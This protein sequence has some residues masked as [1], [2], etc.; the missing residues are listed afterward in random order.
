MSNE[1]LYPKS[2]QVPPMKFAN[3]PSDMQ[4]L[5]D[6][7]SGEWVGEQK[8]DGAWYQLE[9]SED[10]DVF[11]F[12]RTV[13]KK[14]GEY[15]EKSDNVPHIVE[16]A[17]MSMPYGTT[18][19]GEIYVP[20]GKS[21]DVTKIMGCTPQNAY[22][23][24]FESNAYGGP[25]HYYL[26]DCIRYEGQDLTDVPLRE[27]IAI[28]EDFIPT[29]SQYVEVAEHYYDNFEQH[30]QEI[31]AAGGEGMVFKNL[32][33]VYRPGK[34]T[35]TKQAYKYK[36]H[37]DS[38]DL[39]CMSLEEPTMEYTGKEIST[40]PY[41]YSCEWDK[42]YLWNFDPN[43]PTSAPYSFDDVPDIMAVT[44]PFFYNWCNAMRL[45]AY[46][47]GE[48]VEVC[49]VA[50]GLT[51]A[52]RADMGENPENWIGEVIEIEAM[53]VDSKEG[54]VRHPVYLR[55]RDDKSPQDC[56]WDEIFT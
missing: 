23:R 36:E 13:S 6:W 49:R 4:I 55:K 2:C 1:T 48:L 35:V 15:T 14:T 24:Q 43:N 34:R 25:I 8:R 41:W 12:G 18:L 38:I 39:V 20:G 50:S 52:D 5:R 29:H 40:W 37:M 10:G 46:K 32:N 9:V 3:K 17:N 30:L 31:F 44:K 42:N 19:I 11:L 54:S 33:S 45:G 56:L 26:F 22:K 53:S 27:R 51:D 21:N 28:L 7:E 47:D 16:W